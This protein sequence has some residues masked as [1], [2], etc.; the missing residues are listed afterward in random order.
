MKKTIE[1]I[2]EER[3]RAAA[4]EMARPTWPPKLALSAYPKR[5]PS[6]H[7]ATAVPLGTQGDVT[8]AMVIAG[9]RVWLEATC[10]V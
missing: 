5:G 3:M 10:P 4:A 2:R 8:L 1:Q 6:G 9:K 7:L